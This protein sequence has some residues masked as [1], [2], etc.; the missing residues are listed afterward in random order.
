MKSLCKWTGSLILAGVLAA[1]LVAGNE[2]PLPAA[3]RATRAQVPAANPKDV[4]S[5]ETVI[6][7]VYDAI[8]GPQGQRDWNRFRSLFVD[9]ARLVALDPKDGGFAPRVMS[10]D[11]FIAY[12]VPLFEKEGFYEREAAHKTESWANM[13]QVF[14]TYESRHAASDAK[15]FVR[16]INS[17]QLMNDG[18]RWW[19]ICVFWQEES[20][21]NPIPAKFLRTSK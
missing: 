19:V 21:T 16:G 15:P 2:K 10:M 18:K 5:P 4:A 12:V 14:S 3:A 11:E 1:P 17:F 7:A 8:S 6:G 20:A 9:G 13:Q